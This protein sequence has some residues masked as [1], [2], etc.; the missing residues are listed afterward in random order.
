MDSFAR[1]LCYLIGR[2]RFYHLVVKALVSGEMRGGLSRVFVGKLFAQGRCVGCVYVCARLLL[3]PHLFRQ[4]KVA[5]AAFIFSAPA[6][7][8]ERRHLVNELS[9]GLG[10][11]GQ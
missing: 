7:A 9:Y 10:W 2:V 5:R 11:L 8:D 1:L 3:L 4:F 6:A